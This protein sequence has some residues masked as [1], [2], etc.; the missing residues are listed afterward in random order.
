MRL[1]KAVSFCASMG[2]LSVAADGAT[3]VTVAATSQGIV[4]E[5]GRNNAAFGSALGNML[6]GRLNTF[7]IRNFAVFTLGP[8]ARPNGRRIVAATFA[9]RISF[10]AVQLVE[11][12]G[13][14]VLCDVQPA[15][16]PLLAAD[17]TPFS[18]RLDIYNDLAS[19][20]IYGERVVTPADNPVSIPATL[21][22]ALTPAFVQAAN[23]LLDTGGGSI[24]LGGSMVIP[25][26]PG[27]QSLFAFSSYNPPLGGR[28]QLILTIAAACPSDLNADNVVDDLDFQ[29][30]VVQ[31]DILACEDPAMPAGCSADLNGDLIVEDADFSVFVVAYDAVLCP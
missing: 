7:F 9:P 20:V 28:A 30:F 17:A 25:T 13:K 12:P 10:N 26:T 4:D 1:L 27:V 14:Y 11:S 19:G 24:A 23:A 2:V 29:I 8:E 16:V 21:D 31:Y 22:V 18:G 5:F 15:F 6:C 3:T